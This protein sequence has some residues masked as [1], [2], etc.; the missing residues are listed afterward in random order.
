MMAAPL[1]EPCSLNTSHL[2]VGFKQIS[3]TPVQWLEAL[4]D[5]QQH[6]SNGSTANIQK[7]GGNVAHTEVL[8]TN[9]GISVLSGVQRLH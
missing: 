5:S 9:L 3:V 7:G 1:L 6:Y 4:L 2:K 8:N